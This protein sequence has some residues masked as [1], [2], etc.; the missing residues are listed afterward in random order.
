M[1]E[2]FS[3]RGSQI[4]LFVAVAATMVFIRFVVF[5]TGGAPATIDAGNWLA[6]GDALLG[7]GIRDASIVYPP[8]VPLLTKLSVGLFGLTAGVAL[9]GAVVSA[10]PAA[11]LF[12]TLGA[13]GIG[14][15]RLI[16][17]LLLLAAGSVGEAVAWGGFPQ[18]LAMGVLPY[19]V[20]VGY[21][22]LQAPA[23]RAAI[24]MGLIVMLS[25][26]IS[27]FVS[28]V[29][30]T[31]VALLFVHRVVSERSLGEIPA[32]L[33]LT[34]VVALPSIWLIPIYWGLVDAVLLQPNEF[35]ELDNLTLSN[36]L[37]RLEHIYSDAPLLWRLLVPLTVITPW[38]AWR[39]RR[40]EQMRVFS[41]LFFATI[42]LLVLTR[43]GRYLYLLPVLAMLASSVWLTETES[44]YA[45]IF[46]A[47]SARVTVGA[48]AGVLLVLGG[49]AFAGIRQLDNQRDFYA[50]MR[51]PLV[52]A[53][54]FAAEATDEG[55][56][57]AIPSLRGAPIG[58]WVEALADRPVLYGSALRWLNFADEVDRAS[59]ANQI[60]QPNFP[61]L[62]TLPLLEASSVSVVVL[63]RTWIFF[64]YNRTSEWVESSG[65]EMIFVNGDAM[66]FSVDGRARTD[67]VREA[68]QER[69]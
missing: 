4:V 43:E 51:P 63:P 37:G 12:H 21:R 18:L 6:F 5:Y 34:P 56:V 29:L 33:R 1:A 13:F 10:A 40:S 48:T 7:N 16:P 54:E 23:P 27:H 65:V 46:S 66:V 28:V 55:D 35:A 15:I 26:A 44:R 31:A 38:L 22:F 61:N 52:E 36:L 60:F 49:Q 58:W 57:I 8:V 9:V 19:G 2:L 47:L 14:R 45:G 50:V 32:V 3:T 24:R 25:L 68:N 42:V 11:G 30:V 39:D 17:S 59:R 64:D 69:S 67:Q 53:I 41:S 20:L 62:A